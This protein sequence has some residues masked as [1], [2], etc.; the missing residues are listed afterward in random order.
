[1]EH[2]YAFVEPSALLK[3]IADYVESLID[4]DEVGYRRVS[5]MVRV[6]VEDGR[7]FILRFHYPHDTRWEITKRDRVLTV[8]P[9][10]YEAEPIIINLDKDHIKEVR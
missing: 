2:V 1:M 10:H 8:L 9:K 7:P 6:N 4:G 3:T 5:D